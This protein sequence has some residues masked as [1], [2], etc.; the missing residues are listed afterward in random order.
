MYFPT[1]TL[2]ISLSAALIPL[3]TLITGTPSPSHLERRK[4]HDEGPPLNFVY[5]MRQDIDYSDPEAH[6]DVYAEDGTVA[7]QFVKKTLDPQKGVSTAELTTGDS[8]LVFNL[9]S[10]DDACGH[11]SV[12]EEREGTGSQTR[13]VEIYPRGPL[14]DVWRLNYFDS[15]GVRRNFKFNRGFSDKGGSI[16]TQVDG[17]DGDLIAELKNEKRKDSWLTDDDDSKGV[18]TLTL[19]CAEDSPRELLIAFMGIGLSRVNE[20]GL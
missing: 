2:T 14:K 16:Y 9:D 20:C 10:T 8:D 4:H 11:D 12:Y 19:F 6:L 1:I 7:Y 3:A 17:H 13:R 5:I 18:S 15:D